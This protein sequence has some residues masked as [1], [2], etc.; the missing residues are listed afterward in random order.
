MLLSTSSFERKPNRFWLVSMTLSLLVALAL[1]LTAE[2]Y[3]REQG[4]TPR[5]LDS[6]MLW[7]LE[8]SKATTGNSLVFVG[9]S[10]TQFGIHPPTVKKLLP[11]YQ[12]IM[13]AVNG[14]YPLSTLRNLAEDPQFN[15]TVLLDVDARGMIKDFWWMQQPYVDYYE[16]QFT[17]NWYIHRLFLNVWQKHTVISRDAMSITETIA[18]TLDTGRMPW[19]PN[20]ELKSSRAGHLIF[21][22]ES[23]KRLAKNFGDQLEQFLE[24]HPPPPADQ[25]LQE[26]NLL[27]QWIETIE[28]R[29][30]KVILYEPPVSGRQKS[31]AE[32]FLPKEQY[33]DQ[34][35]STYH[36]TAINYQEEPT[37]QAFE[38]PDE[39]HVKGDSRDEYTAALIQL[40]IDKGLVEP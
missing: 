24:D 13:L 15:G 16:H 39:S 8:R 21:T 37:L 17:P 38:Q 5:I 3:W 40:M 9:A 35:I 33:W 30:G 19:K 12:P 28:N 23:A 2:Y 14:M 20:Y 11:H 27:A 32:S 22:E 6:A 18:R 1:C 26:L 29:G 34:L 31:L 4:Y 25:W 36:L 10:R 7:S